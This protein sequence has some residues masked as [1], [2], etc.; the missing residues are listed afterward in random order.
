MLRSAI[1]KAGTKEGRKAG[2]WVGAGVERVVP[3]AAT[4]GLLLSVGGGL[5][6]CHGGGGQRHRWYDVNVGCCGRERY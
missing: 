2:C 4:G 3:C 6:K 1:D 5:G